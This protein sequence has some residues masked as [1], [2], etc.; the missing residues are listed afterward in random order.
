MRGSEFQ[1]GVTWSVTISE[2]EIGNTVNNKKYS[3]PEYWGEIL[4]IFKL[5]PAYP[6]SEKW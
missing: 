6:V 5:F 1:C 3:N 4:R 2:R